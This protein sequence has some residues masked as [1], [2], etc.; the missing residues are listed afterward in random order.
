MNGSEIF[1]F[2]LSS[3]PNL[4]L[5]VLSKN[6]I[7]HNEVDYFILH[8]ANAYMLEFLRKKLKIDP[9]KFY[10]GFSEIGNTVSSTIPIA[11]C[12]AKEKNILHQ[13]M[14]VVLAGFGVGYSWAGCLL[15]L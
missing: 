5:N 14:N 11:I 3:V 13:D 7:A 2:T 4:I 9:A 15:K 1:S 10:L 12:D 6:E 8:Q